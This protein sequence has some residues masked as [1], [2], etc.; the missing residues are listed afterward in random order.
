MIDIVAQLNSIHREVA[1]GRI[2]GA[3]AVRVVIRREL[4][5]PIDDVWDACTDPERIARWFLPVTGE[6]KVGG[7]YQLRGNAGG[8]ILRCDPPVLV[9][10]TWEFGDLPP[11]EV[12]VRLTP[13]GDERTLFVL[14]HVAITD[15]EMWARFGPGAVGVGWDLTVLGLSLHL[16]AAAALEPEAW[17][18]TPEYREFATGSATAWGAAH[19][20]FGAAADEAAAAVGNTTAFYVPVT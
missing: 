15:P 3:D 6:L 17:Q 5:A 10:V 9:R 8:E 16:T 18:R 20:K 11:S 19:E 14:E 7:R 12:E 1:T 13:A 2:G 4:D